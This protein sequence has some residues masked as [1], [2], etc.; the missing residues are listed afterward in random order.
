MVLPGV[1]PADAGPAGIATLSPR[2]REVLTL[3][4]AG[5]SN[6]AISAAL[7]ISYPTVK[8]HV[9]H[10]LDKLGTRDRTSAAVLAVNAGLWSDGSAA[11][12]S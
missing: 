8:T 5:R 6:R 12:S 1:G 3:L 9:S 7:F 4:A 10:I 11:G 2:E